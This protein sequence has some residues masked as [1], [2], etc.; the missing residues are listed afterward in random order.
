MEL[1]L[2]VVVGAGFTAAFYNKEKVVAFIKSKL[3][4]AKMNK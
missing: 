2:G 3:D 4:A 1:I